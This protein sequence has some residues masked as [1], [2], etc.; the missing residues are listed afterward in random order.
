MQ[1]K[2]K[3]K[4]PLSFSF[5]LISINILSFSLK[6]EQN[7]KNESNFVFGIGV[8]D[9]INIDKNTIEV[10]TTV[11]IYSDKTKKTEIGDLKTSNIF[12]VKDMKMH[13]QKEDNIIGFPKVILA[14]LV[15]ISIS[16]TRGILVAKAA[17]TALAKAIIP[18]INPTNMLR[19]TRAKRKTGK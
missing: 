9:K 5:K 4:K 1:P 3:L 8:Q 14:S 19:G 17:G 13:I 12:E 10:I 6:N 15:G 18:I 7:L 2:E 16:N 11:I